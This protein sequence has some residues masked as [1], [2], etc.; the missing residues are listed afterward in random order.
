MLASEKS[1]W[2]VARIRPGQ[3]ERALT[4]LDRASV[5]HMYPRSKV[6]NEFEPII[7]GYVFVRLNGKPEF[8][9]ISEIVGIDGLLPRGAET[10]SCVP[11]SWM[12]AF[13]DRLENGEYDEAVEQIAPTVFY[14]KNE[15]V[16]VS[17]GPFSGQI[18]K[19]VCRRKGRIE[20]E[21]PMFGQTL[22]VFVL[23]HQVQKLN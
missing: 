11:S 23:A 19:F 16:L 12:R 14:Q 1:E 13:I 18:A 8:S 17:S 10:P 2:Y 4:N 15:K 9:M 3:T 20:V 7:P 6:H 21:L 5:E 22:G